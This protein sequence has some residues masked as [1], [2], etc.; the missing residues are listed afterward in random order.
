MNLERL[1]NESITQAINE[2]VALRRESGNIENVIIALQN[3]YN[4][5]LNQGAS[6][7]EFTI[8]KIERMIND[9]KSINKK[10]QN[11]SMW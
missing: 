11:M 1:I 5:V 2:A 7:H 4:R 3:I 10:W 9:L 6:P 8:T